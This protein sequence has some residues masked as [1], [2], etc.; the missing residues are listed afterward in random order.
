RSDEAST[1]RFSGTE[2]QYTEGKKLPPRNASLLAH[3]LKLY[4]AGQS[5]RSGKAEIARHS[6]TLHRQWPIFPAPTNTRGDRD[7][8]ISSAK[9]FPKIGRR[10]Y[11]TQCHETRIAATRR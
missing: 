7:Y 2:G 11:V 9:V 10:F 8:R 5:A 4:R 1:H 3:A 6:R